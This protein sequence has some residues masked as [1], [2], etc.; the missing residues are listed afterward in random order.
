VLNVLTFRDD[1]IVAI[2]AFLD[3]ALLARFGLPAIWPGDP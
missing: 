2:S 3:S 1:R